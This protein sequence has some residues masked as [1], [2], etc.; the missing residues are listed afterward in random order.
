MG[1][2]EAAVRDDNPSEY[3]C[4][5]HGT[6]IEVHRLASEHLKAALCYQKKTYDLKL[7]QKHFVLGDFVYKLNVINKKGECKKLKP[8]WIGPLLVTQVLSPV[9]YKVKDRH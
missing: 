8:I 2:E 3:L 9:L 7:Q 5:L 6:L 1:I 4:K